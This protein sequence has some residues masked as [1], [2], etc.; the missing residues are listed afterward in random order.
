M[1]TTKD[2]KSTTQQQNREG[3][4]PK[5][6]GSNQPNR[7]AGASS[8]GKTRYAE[9]A[10]DSSRQFGE[11]E[12]EAQQNKSRP[13]EDHVPPVD[14][15]QN[16]AGQP[17]GDDSAEMPFPAG[18]RQPGTRQPDGKRKPAKGPG[19]P[20]DDQ[21]D[22]MEVGQPGGLKARNA[23]TGNRKPIEHPSPKSR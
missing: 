8:T 16:A 21:G 13:Q 7:N 12:T 6:S 23:E 18:D 9:G 22:E 10:P 2:D 20:I 11:A 15:N 17:A 4:T 3:S 14:R 1:A 5:N 19:V